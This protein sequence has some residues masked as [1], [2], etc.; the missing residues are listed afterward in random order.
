MINQ[1]I[2]N[3]SYNKFSKHV[4]QDITDETLEEWWRVRESIW[5]EAILE[6]ARGE[7]HLPL[8]T[9]PDAKE[10]LGTVQ[11]FFCEN[12]WMKLF[13]SWGDKCEFHWVVVFYCDSRCKFQD[14]YLSHTPLFTVYN[15]VKWK[16][17]LVPSNQYMVSGLVSP[18]KRILLM[19]KM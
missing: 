8:I 10:V 4:P 12:L 3:V 2:V 18:Q 11:I 5:H 16:H 14:F 7:G 13:Q 15:T 19:N 6:V 1:Y 9:F 17:D